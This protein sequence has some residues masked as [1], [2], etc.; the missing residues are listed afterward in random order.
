MSGRLAKEREAQ[1]GEPPRKKRRLPRGVQGVHAEDM[2]LVTPD[3]VAHRGGWKITP[4]GRLI[5]PIRTR[6]EHPLPEPVA[7][8]V[9]KG[10][11]KD[12]TGKEKKRKRANEPL[13]RARRQTIDPLKY[14]SQQV[15]GVFLESLVVEP[16]R[17]VPQRGAEQQLGGESSEE[18]EEEN[19]SGGEGESE[20]QVEKEL[21]P[22]AVQTKAQLSKEKLQP[23]PPASVPAPTPVPT[24]AATPLRLT[25]TG[26]PDLTQEKNAALGLLQS[27]FGDDDRN[28]G[29]EETLSDVDMDGLTSRRRQVQDDEHEDDIEVVLTAVNAR[30]AAAPVYPA[31]EEEGEKEEETEGRGPAEKATS[32]APTPTAPAA[33]AAKLK[34][35][36]APREEE[37]GPIDWFISLTLTSPSYSQPCFLC[38]VIWTSTS[39][40]T[41]WIQRLPYILLLLPLQ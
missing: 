30:T 25:A 31:E 3:N 6:P 32:P 19:E 8:A 34:D 4:L 13:T 39:S 14:G 21:L 20:M 17:E 36:F 11:R 9:A 16:R 28:W 2:S 10:K 15:K 22:P 40:T 29:G 18:S 24:A 23:P 1:D 35:L 37:G 27:L 38:W 41:T 12:K 7:T 5:R 26:G 33:K